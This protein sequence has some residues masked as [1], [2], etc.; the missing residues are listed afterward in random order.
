M[1]R[2]H[3]CMCWNNLTLTLQVQHWSVALTRMLWFA[4]GSR[5]GAHLRKTSTHAAATCLTAVLLLSAAQGSDAAN[6]PE[7]ESLGS[8]IA[9]SDFGKI[10]AGVECRAVGAHTLA[11]SIRC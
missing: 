11:Y 6:T 9:Y 3:S 7:G 1:W 8:R 10:V 4:A 5:S 2:Q